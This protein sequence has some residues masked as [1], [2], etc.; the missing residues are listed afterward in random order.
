[1]KLKQQT[2]WNKYKLKG[3]DKINWTNIWN[4]KDENEKK[5]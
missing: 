3:T 5:K 2:N 4:Q 1:M